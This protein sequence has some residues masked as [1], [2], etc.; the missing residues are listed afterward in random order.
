MIPPILARR[1]KAGFWFAV[2]LTGV[3]TGLAAAALT[4]LLE[5]TQ[6]LIWGGAGLDLLQAASQAPPR[7]HLVVLTAAGLLTGAG[8][9]LI[10]RLS[11]ANGIDITAAIWFQ[12]GRLPKF[13]TCSAPRFRS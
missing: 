12:A 2:V 11:S 7:K 6:H 3:G 9:L 5:L 13:R 1:D 8:Q 4:G 10:T